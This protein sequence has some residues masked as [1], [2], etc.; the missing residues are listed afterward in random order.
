[1]HFLIVLHYNRSQY[2]QQLTVLTILIFFQE[3]TGGKDNEEEED[4]D[5]EDALKWVEVAKRR[6]LFLLEDAKAKSN[7]LRDE[8]TVLAEAER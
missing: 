5:E 1:M 7:R 3:V 2:I 6:K 4:V 8:G